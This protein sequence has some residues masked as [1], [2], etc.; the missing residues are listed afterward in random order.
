MD[1]ATPSELRAR[2]WTAGRN[3]RCSAAWCP[4]LW[5][6]CRVERPRSGARPEGQICFWET[7]CP[8]SKPRQQ[9]GKFGSMSGLATGLLSM[10]RVRVRGGSRVDGCRKNDRA[11]AS[12]RSWAVLF[13]HP[14]DF[15]P[16]CTTELG[17][18]SKLHPEFT[19]RGI[20][21]AVLTRHRQ[22]A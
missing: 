12:M 1:S 19:R 10:L 14:A 9:Q 11:G 16:V 6:T 18:L 5:K 2:E 15:T 17:D 4:D 7:S 21:C 8:I 3:G 20:S 22:R 13:S